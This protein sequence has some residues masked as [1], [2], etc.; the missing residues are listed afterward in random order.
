M[1][2]Q[3]FVNLPVRDLQ[4]SIDFFTKLG[5]A[6][7]QQFT[8]E[9]STCMIVN[10]HAYVMLLVEPFFQ[11]FTKKTLSDTAKTTECIIAISAD[12]RA[13]VDELADKALQ[14]G[15]AQTID[16]TDQGFMYSRAFQDLDGHMWE[17]IYMDTAALG[18]QQ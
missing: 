15:G 11:G 8:D 12:S 7:N 3:I 1:A 14:A 2:T 10:E 9:K 17:V 16:A 13:K 6:F 18:G 4:K 5:F